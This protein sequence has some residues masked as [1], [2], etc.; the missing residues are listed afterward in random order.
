MPRNLESEAE[1]ATKLDQLVS[2][3]TMLS[4]L[5]VVDNPSDELERMQKEEEDSSVL[6]QRLDRERNGFSDR[7]LY[8][9]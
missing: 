3:K 8:D 9:E 2:K 5:S 4:T 1:T 7:D 6:S